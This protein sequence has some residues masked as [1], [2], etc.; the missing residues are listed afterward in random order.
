L[1]IPMAFLADEAN[2]SQEGKLNVLGI[3]D[4]IAAAEFPVVH[5]RMVFAFRVQ[6]EYADA[7]Q[8]LVVRVRMVDEDGGVMFEANGEISPPSVPPG[9]FATANQ[10][11]TLVGVQFP[12]P[13]SYKFIVNL[14]DLDP[15]ETPFT[16]AR[17]AAEEQETRE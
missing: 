2:V 13:G 8:N 12:H 7:G 11:F 14:G 5:P 1:R 17:A 9:E 3:F 4:R 16:V 15:H 6:A 10:V